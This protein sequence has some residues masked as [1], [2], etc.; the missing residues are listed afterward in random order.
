MDNH[1]KAQ[2]SYNM[3]RVQNKNTSSELI[4]RKWLWANGYRYRL[5]DRKLPG[6]PD[7][8]FPGRKKVIFI[9]GCFW[10]KHDCKYFKYPATS[11]EFW[12]D[13]LDANAMRDQENYKNLKELGWNI[14][15]IWTC[16]LKPKVINN[17]CFRLVNFIDNI[18]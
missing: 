15:I 18:R 10:H 13:K 7:I 14:L 11:T 9:N 17:L 5:N 12:V 6:K 3:S 1:T 8:V 2:R 16:E 4:I